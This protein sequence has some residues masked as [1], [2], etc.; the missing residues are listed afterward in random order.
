MKRKLCIFYVNVLIIY[1]YIQFK[2]NWGNCILMLLITDFGEKS[3]LD[4]SKKT[5]AKKKFSQNVHNVKALKLLVRTV[6]WQEVGDM[7][8][9]LTQVMI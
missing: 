8:H 5:A 9:I 3:K 2:T 4:C 6:Y 1:P 7:I